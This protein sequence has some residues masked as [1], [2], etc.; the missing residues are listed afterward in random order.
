MLCHVGADTHSTHG[1]AE[2][3]EQ[4]TERVLDVAILDTAAWGWALHTP[5]CPS[6][7]GRRRAPHA[8]GFSLHDVS[9]T[10][11]TLLTRIL[12]HPSPPAHLHGR[13][14]SHEAARD[15]ACHI[16]YSTV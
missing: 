7:V 15:T 2:M 6:A 8:R 16:L 10:L 13:S 9:R 4:T 14:L 11:V 12:I 3:R 1:L 5:H